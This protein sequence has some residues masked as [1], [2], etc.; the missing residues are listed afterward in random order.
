MPSSYSSPWLI[1]YRD[2][3]SKFR[4]QI[5]LWPLLPVVCPKDWGCG[6]LSLP[7]SVWTRVP[8]GAVAWDRETLLTSHSSVWLLEWGHGISLT[9]THGLRVAGQIG[10]L[11]GAG[12]LL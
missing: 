4:Q 6:S 7:G 12:I 10:Y 2:V 3:Q 9:Q 1:S 8:L 5:T 11:E